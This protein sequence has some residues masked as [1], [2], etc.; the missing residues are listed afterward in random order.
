MGEY[1][2][3]EFGLLRDM[4]LGIAG[5]VLAGS[6]VSRYIVFDDLGMLSMLLTGSIGAVVLVAAQRTLLRSGRG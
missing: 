5:S 4:A 6:V 3:R 2:A 1:V